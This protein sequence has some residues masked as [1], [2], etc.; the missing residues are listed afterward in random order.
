MVELVYDAD[1]PHTDLARGQLARALERLGLEPRWQ[2]WRLDNPLAPDRVRGFGSPTILV[3]G[4]DVGGMQPP[5]RE[6]RSC[7]VYLD[8]GGGLQGA[9]SVDEIVRALRQVSRPE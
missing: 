7:R 2:E 8:Q 5:S 3:E 9:P 4:V 1:C 6:T